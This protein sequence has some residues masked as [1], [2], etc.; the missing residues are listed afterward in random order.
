MSNREPNPGE[1]LPPPGEPRAPVEGS[2]QAVLQLDGQLKVVWISQAG[3]DLFGRNPDELAGR[4]CHQAICRLELPCE[5]CPVVDCL[6]CQAPRQKSI[7]HPLGRRLLVRAY[8]VRAAGGPGQG[9][10]VVVRE[11][12]RWKEDWARLACGEGQLQALFTN[13]TTGLIILEG[14]GQKASLAANPAA[15][16]I[17]GLALTSPQEWKALCRQAVDELGH[18]LDPARLPTSLAQAQGNPRPALVMGIPDPHQ[19]GR[20][21]MRVDAIPLHPPGQAPL[22]IITLADITHLKLAL[23]A[24]QEGHQRYRGLVTTMSEGL[25][26]L[27]RQGNITFA[28]QPLCQITGFSQEEM[29]GRP[30]WR[31]FG[32][33]AREMFGELS[34]ARA[35]TCHT[36][37]LSWK[38]RQGQTR[39]VRV[40]VRALGEPGGEFGGAQAVLTD[41]TSLKDAQA[42]QE[43]LINELRAALH[44]VKTLSGLIP[45]CASC[46]RVRNDQGYWEQIE[47]YLHQHSSA[48]FS[49]GL[50]PSCADLLYPELRDDY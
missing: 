27:D 37:D 26:T 14:Q 38:N 12:P 49:H 19:Q 23:Q 44:E 15:Q 35:G 40:S 5:Q 47:A 11:A 17:T 33:Q 43:K 30:A 46:K 31:V 18:P 4:R 9:A 34:Q 2:D 28:N 45:I 25:G 22:V 50:C 42:R 41:I 8:P 39:H 20:R 10:M 36:Y 48:Q 29:V 6:A 13:M 7:L 21:W 16:K 32:P 24:L 3:A 1:P